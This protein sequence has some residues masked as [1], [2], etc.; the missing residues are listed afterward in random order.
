[1]CSFSFTYGTCPD[2]LM[3]IHMCTLIQHY[4]ACPEVVRSLQLTPSKN[5]SFIMLL[6]F[7]SQHRGLALTDLYV[8]T[9]LEACLNSYHVLCIYLTSMLMFH[10]QALYICIS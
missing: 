9:M 3:D 4:G 2:G 8:C 10:A 1:M 5:L 6:R 7:C